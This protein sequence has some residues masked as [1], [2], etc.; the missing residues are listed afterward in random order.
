MMQYTK[1]LK[2][3]IVEYEKMIKRYERN[4]EYNLVLFWKHQLRSVKEQIAL[5]EKN[6]EAN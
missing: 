3:K 6:E 5:M 2:R 4:E 1:N